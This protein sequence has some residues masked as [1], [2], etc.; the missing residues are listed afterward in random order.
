LRSAF[1]APLTLFS[2]ASASA[3]SVD[4]VDAAPSPN[5]KIAVD[6]KAKASD[7]A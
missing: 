1:A 7:S 6:A 3:P 2:R 4:A 5:A